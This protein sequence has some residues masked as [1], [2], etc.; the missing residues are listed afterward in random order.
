MSAPEYT[1]SIHEL[2]RRAGAGKDMVLDL[3][4]PADMGTEV[5]GVPEGSPLHLDLR[6]ESASDG[7]YVSGSVTGELE[8]QCVRCLD[9]IREELDMTVAELYLFPE[10]LARAEEDGDEEAAEMLT[11]DG[12]T[13]D[14]EP[15]VRDTVVTEL[16]FQP[17]CR[18]DCPGL[19]P[20]CGIRM[21]DAEEG[22]GHEVID[23]RFA[24]LAGLLAEVDV[25][26]EDEESG[27]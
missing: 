15:M 8:G 11:T 3:P 16:P 20:E 23:P 6:V 14:L 24:A 12:E 26:G 1:I 4:A 21:E 9:P 25:E 27:Q 2:A 19:C 10:S 18:A 22:H 13:L 17:L 7:V 5:I